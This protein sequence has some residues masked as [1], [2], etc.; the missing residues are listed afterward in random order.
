MNLYLLD[1]TDKARRQIKQVLPEGKRIEI[2]ETILDLRE[3]PFPPDSQ[4]ER[5]LSERYR[6][7]VN[8]WRILYV[9]NEE[10]KIVTVLSV[11]KRNRNT[12][13]NVP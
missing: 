7:K 10:D 1:V 8:G 5:E 9:V 3:A 12:Y 13:L 11:R 6:L 2:T 4:L